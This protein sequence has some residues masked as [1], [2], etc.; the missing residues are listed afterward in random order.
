[1]IELTPEQRKKIYEEEKLKIEGEGV[2]PIGS[3]IF[4][5]IVALSFLFLLIGISKRK[6][7]PKIEDIRKVYEGVEPE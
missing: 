3:L 1:M 4:A 5:N 6:F 2:G 7:V